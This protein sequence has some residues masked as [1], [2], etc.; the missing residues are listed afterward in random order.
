[1]LVRFRLLPA[2]ILGDVDWPA[3]PD[4]ISL[5]VVATR[6][7]ELSL[8]WVMFARTGIAELP[9]GGRVALYDTSDRRA[10]KCDLTPLQQPEG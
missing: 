6:P 1:M 9:D 8:G 10:R 5:P 4:Q 7:G 3:M 2:T